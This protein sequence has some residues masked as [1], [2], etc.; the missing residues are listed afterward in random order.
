MRCQIISVK[1]I[2]LTSRSEGDTE[3]VNLEDAH[4]V[5]CLHTEEK[6]EES[7]AQLPSQTR[8]SQQKSRAKT[9]RNFDRVFSFF[10]LFRKVTSS[11]KETECDITF[12]RD[13]IDN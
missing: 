10:P 1:I 2:E 7:E 5:Y 11:G 13:D 3:T 8:A 9:A 6:N 12:Y 4:S